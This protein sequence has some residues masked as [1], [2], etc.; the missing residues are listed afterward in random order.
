MPRGVYH[1]FRN[2]LH[3]TMFDR[4]RMLALLY[5]ISPRGLVRLKKLL[6]LADRKQY[7]TKAFSL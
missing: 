2:A 4:A 5:Q 1:L 3:G 6:V 7:E